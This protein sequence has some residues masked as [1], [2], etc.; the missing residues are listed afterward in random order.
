[1]P[2]KKT[3]LTTSGDVV[4]GLQVGEQTYKEISNVYIVNTTAS[5]VSVSMYIM[6]HPTETSAMSIDDTVG[7]NLLLKDFVIPANQTGFN[8]FGQMYLQYNQSLVGVSDTDDA[9]HIFVSYR[10]IIEREIVNVIDVK[11]NYT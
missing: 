1:M 3:I 10:N 4:S 2:I 5:D 8:N 9:C 7:G 11:Q 6:N